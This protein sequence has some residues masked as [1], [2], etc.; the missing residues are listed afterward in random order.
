MTEAARLPRMRFSRQP[1]N[2]GE[3]AHTACEGHTA[4]V[5]FTICGDFK[6]PGA[7]TVIRPLKRM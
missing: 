5:I 1:C 4:Q 2:G 3:I 7:V 6:A